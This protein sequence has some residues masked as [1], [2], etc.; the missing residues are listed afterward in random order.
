MLSRQNSYR[1]LTQEVYKPDSVEG[2]H[3]STLDEMF[4]CACIIAESFES[5]WFQRSIFTSC[6]KV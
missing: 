1:I 3:L 5:K 2:K 6:Y 4:A